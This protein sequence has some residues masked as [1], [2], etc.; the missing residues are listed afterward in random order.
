MSD[1]NIFL[2]QESRN[3]CYDESNSIVEITQVFRFIEGLKWVP[4]C[5][6]NDRITHVT[7]YSCEYLSFREG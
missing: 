4:W 5:Y 6:G 7:N 2:I 1:I 3:E